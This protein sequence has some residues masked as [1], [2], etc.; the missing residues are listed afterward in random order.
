MPAD[1][2]EKGVAPGTWVENSPPDEPRAPKDARQRESAPEH[3]HT[4][5]GLRTEVLDTT[6]SS[7][8]HLDIG[9]ADRVSA[10][11]VDSNRGAAVRSGRPVYGNRR[12]ALETDSVGKDRHGG[13][14]QTDVVRV[15]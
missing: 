8:G 11:D 5:V 2:V 12:D 7:E 9:I 14:S 10:G 15:R 3:H 6:S 13:I 1:R 4:L